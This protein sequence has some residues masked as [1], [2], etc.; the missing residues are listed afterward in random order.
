[1]SG[2]VTQLDKGKLIKFAK[3]YGM[4]RYIHVVPTQ[5]D[6]GT[7]LKTLVMKYHNLDEDGH[8]KC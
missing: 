6:M 7:L 8:K 1:V 4:S 3:D 5:D 2:E